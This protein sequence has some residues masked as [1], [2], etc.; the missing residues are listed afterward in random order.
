M[1]V[2]VVQHNRTLGDGFHR[3]VHQSISRLD[4]VRLVVRPLNHGD[5]AGTVSDDSLDAHFVD[6]K[7]RHS[8]WP[9][10]GILRIAALAD[11][12]D[13]GITTPFRVVYAGRSSLGLFR[14][15]LAA[16]RSSGCRRR[17]RWLSPLSRTT[18][19]R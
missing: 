14:C 17:G 16:R 4:H 9:C 15:G 18:L 19:R 13:E 2:I 12:A 3:A 7:S 10:A 1:L 11:Q 8:G 6:E 5:E